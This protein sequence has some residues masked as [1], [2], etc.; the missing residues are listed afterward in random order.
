MS[1]LIAYIVGAFAYTW[2]FHLRIVRNRW[3]IEKGQGR[4]L[5]WL[6]LPGPTL[7]AIAI[8]LANGSFDELLGHLLVWPISIQWWLIGLL[9]IPATYLLATG[10]HSIRTGQRPTRLFHRPSL[11]WKI[12]LLSQVAVV[13]SEEIGW[14]GFALPLLVQRFGSLGG[15]L[16]LGSVWSMWHLPMF[17]VPSSHQKGS[18]LGFTFSLTAWSVIMT[19]TVVGSGGSI[20]PAMLFHAAANVSHFVMDVPT[21][22]EPYSAAVLGMFAALAV[23]LLPD[24]LLTFIA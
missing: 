8:S 23:L 11:G 2:A 5:Y 15:T 1:T 18:F 10:L 16:I 4:R 17:R 6:G 9:T 19:A 12:L 13:G 20:L 24:P 7:A 3:S 14:R 21:E 22:A